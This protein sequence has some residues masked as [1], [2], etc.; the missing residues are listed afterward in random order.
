MT[1]NLCATLCVSVFEQPTLLDLLCIQLLHITNSG[2]TITS[3]G[4]GYDQRLQ[5]L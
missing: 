5:R 2:V 3:G 4:I 1:L